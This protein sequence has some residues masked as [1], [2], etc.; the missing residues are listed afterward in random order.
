M[1]HRIPFVPFARL[2][3][4]W[5]RPRYIEWYRPRPPR[6]G[7]PAQ[8]LGVHIVPI[9]VDAGSAEVLA[10]VVL[11]VSDEVARACQVRRI[12][13]EPLRH[14]VHAEQ[15]AREDATDELRRKVACCR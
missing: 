7:Q 9:R 3:A 8:V 4:R 12:E 1:K 14:A 13:H 10:I 5:H 15:K 6:R 2:H 11:T